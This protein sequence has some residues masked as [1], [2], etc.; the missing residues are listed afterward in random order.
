MKLSFHTFSQYVTAVQL[1]FTLI[2]EKIIFTII[3]LY[4]NAGVTLNHPHTMSSLFL[5]LK[6]PVK[7]LKRHMDSI[8]I[9]TIIS[10]EQF[11]L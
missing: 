4:D 9:Y 8:N 6:I 5:A 7:L 10:A 1:L 2:K 3:K 11:I